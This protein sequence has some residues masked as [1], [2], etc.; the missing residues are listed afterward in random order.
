[1]PEKRMLVID[2]ESVVLSSCRRIFTAAGF[3]VVTTESPRQGLELASG[4]RFDVILCDWRM[5]ELDGMIDDGYW[6]YA[7]LLARAM[8]IASG[9]SEV[10]RNI[11]AQRLLGLPR[12]A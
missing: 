6:Q 9:T 1:M 12:G 11:I 10:Q 2:D 5:P 4:S 8:T 7:W 3:E